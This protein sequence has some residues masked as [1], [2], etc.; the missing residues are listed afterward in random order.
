MDWCEVG[1][2]DRTARP[3]RRHGTGR[4]NCGRTVHVLALQGPS[5]VGEGCRPRPVVEGPTA[6]GDRVDPCGVEKV[7]RELETPGPTF[8]EHRR[9][10]GYGR[11]PRPHRANA[12]G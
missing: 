12:T 1:W 4:P 8:H 5:Q 2:T 10:Q 3:R 7:Q 11:R 9:R 6:V